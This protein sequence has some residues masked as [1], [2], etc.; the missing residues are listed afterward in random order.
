MGLRDYFARFVGMGG[1]DQL[2]GKPEKA[3]ETSPVNARPQSRNGEYVLSVREVRGSDGYR[4]RVDSEIVILKEYTPEEREAAKNKLLHIVLT[5]EQLY[6][7]CPRLNRGVVLKRGDVL[8]YDPLK[9]RPIIAQGL[10]R[11]RSRQNM[12]DG[13]ASILSQNPE[14]LEDG[15]GIFD[16]KKE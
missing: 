2:V 6:K 3:S 13:I 8:H 4:V 5:E 9:L 14:G 11:K 16:F 7:V 10:A 12:D 15:S 1:N